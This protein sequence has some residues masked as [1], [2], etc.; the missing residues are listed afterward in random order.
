MTVSTTTSRV[1]YA[2]NGST[3]TFTVPFYFLAAADLTVIR[4]SSAGVQTTL[5]LNTDYTVTGAGVPAGGS[6]T[7][8]VAPSSTDS[9][10]IFRDPAATQLTDYQPN[11]PFPAETHE[12]ALDKLT[13]LAQ[14][15]KDL[16]ARSFTLSD[17]DASGAS[18]Q[19]PSPQANRLIG[20]N[21]SASGLQNVD[22]TTLATIVAFGSTYAQTFTGNGV[23]TAWT[24]AAN[25]G[26]LANLDVSIGGV[27]QLPGVD[28]LWSSG[29]TLTTTSPVPNGVTMLVRYAQALPQGTTDSAASSFLQAGTGAVAR[30]AQAKMRETVSVK[31][32]GA[33]GNNVADDTLS[34]QAALNSGAKRVLAPAGT[35]RFSTLTMPAN[36][37]LLGEGID[38]TIFST[39]TSGNAV[40][41]AERNTFK[42]LT[43]QQTSGIR[44]G[45]GIFGSD[46][47]WLITECVKLL[48]FDYNLYCDKA[49]YH[50]HKQSWFEDGNY[51]A[52]YWGAAGTWNTDWFNNVITFDTCRFNGNTNIGT[53]V[54]G[55]EVVF[56]NPDWSG[57]S[58]TNAI[59]LR[60]VGESVGQPAHGIKVITP[61]AE[62]TDIVFS[63]LFAYVE[64]DAGFVQGGTASGASAA[65]S[66]IDADNSQV[67][68]NGRMR[69]QDYWD[70]G[71]RLSNSSRLIF[72]YGFSGSVRASNSVDATSKVIFVPEYEEGTFT[73]TLTGCTTSPTATAYY[74]RNGKH[75]AISVPQ[76]IGTSNSTACGLTGLPAAL[77]PAREQLM[78]GCF[79]D[80]GAEAAGLIR[81]QT[82]GTINFY[83]AQFGNNFTA[84]GGK[85]CR[86]LTMSYSLN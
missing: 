77:Y 25:P 71:Y 80:N 30:T 19:L 36:V 79:F 44:R 32:F 47:Y 66:I 85:G 55:A 1:V 28:Y 33:V 10:I 46:K 51:G 49:L 73:A 76:I 61:Y 60:V 59:G 11:D 29:T 17:G 74:V 24:L 4:T 56:I 38:V 63:F 57:M 64:I 41:I 2:G 3:V 81:V 62:V 34:I 9:L 43:I 48:G 72:E 65:T 58:A 20:W 23:Q 50:S 70:N 84:A 86:T 40:S 6:V 5:V 31:D 18:T 35:Y 69:D 37:E 75:V 52:Y 27:T 12:R 78:F 21:Q 83:P 7:C 42:D 82:G 16:I 68:W 26:A 39:T 67:W 14:R 13:M 53:Y 54:K 15:L 8:T 45:K 22:S